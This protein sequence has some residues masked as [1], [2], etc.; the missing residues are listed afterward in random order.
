M[1]LL[2]FSLVC[3]GLMN[4]V[5][6]SALFA[7]VR[8]GAAARVPALGKLLSCSM[9]FG[10]WT[11]VLVAALGLPLLPPAALP[12]PGWWQHSL[13]LLLSGWASSGLCWLGYL[14]A[15]RLYKLTF[16]ED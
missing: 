6:T 14:A 4:I 11:G 13:A 9:C 7:P 16:P 2:I 1:H 3:Y 8:E 10:F 5:V 12:G 15:E